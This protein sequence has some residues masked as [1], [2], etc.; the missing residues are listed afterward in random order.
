MDIDNN[1]VA[2]KSLLPVLACECLKGLSVLVRSFFDD[3]L[4]HLDALLAL[5]TFLCQPVTEVLLQ[6]LLV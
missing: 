5:E 2:R 4:G 1:L 6:S 3:R